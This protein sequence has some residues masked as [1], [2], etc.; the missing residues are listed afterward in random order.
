MNWIQRFLTAIA[1][2]KADVNA[3]H[4]MTHGAGQHTDVTR[5]KFL[6]VCE[7]YVVAGTP[8]LRYNYAVVKGGVGAD[9]PQ[10]CFTMEVPDDF[11]SFSSVKAIWLYDGGAIQNMYWTL[12]ANYC[13]CGEAAATHTDEPALGVT[14]SGGSNIK[15]CQEPA[16]PLTLANLTSGDSIGISFARFG[17][18]E[19]DTLATAMYL[20]GLLFTYVGH[21]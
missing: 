10:M 7:G 11:V 13:A 18:H 6:P 20:L 15:N 5:Y 9:E 2:H 4:A 1:T 21:Q 17:T 16:N 3:H 8:D 19:S 12:A 14:A